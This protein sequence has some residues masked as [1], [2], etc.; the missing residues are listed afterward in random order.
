MSTL[1][2]RSVALFVASLSVGATLPFAAS[3]SMNAAFQTQGG[4]ILGSDGTVVQLHRAY[5]WRDRYD[6][7]RAIAIY[8]AYLQLGVKDL[9]KPDINDRS[10]IDVYLKNPVVPRVDVTPQSFDPISTKD[11]LKPEEDVIPTDA[12]TK[13]E[14]AALAR[15][16]KL[17]KC[18]S[19][20]GFSANY[21][22]LCK[23]FIKGKSI[24]P[25]AGL[26]TDLVKTRATGRAA[27]SSSSRSSV[28]VPA[29]VKDYQYQ[30]VIRVLPRNVRGSSSSSR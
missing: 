3:Q 16:E 15:S 20:P 30:S 21:W 27:I 14:R 7:N 2:T 23:K 4:T 28:N 8:E 29:T 1:S 5:S 18:W 6:Y 25:T 10:T 24:L 17:G 9:V 22:K 13:Q 11:Y 12:L 19:Y 26:Q